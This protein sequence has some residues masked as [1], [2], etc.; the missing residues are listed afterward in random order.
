MNPVEQFLF[1]N[2]NT[3][4]GIRKLSNSLGLRKKDV[5]YYA[6][7]SDKLHRMNPMDVGSLKNKLLLFKYND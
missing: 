4:Y 5:I 7:S 3:I 1:D 2:K 6:L